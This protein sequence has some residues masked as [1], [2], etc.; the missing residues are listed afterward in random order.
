MTRRGCEGPPSA[1][2]PAIYQ[3]ISTCLADAVGAGGIARD[4]LDRLLPEAGRALAGL[5][6][7]RAAGTQPFLAYA[8]G[9]DNLAALAALA[10][11]WRRRFRRLVV[12]GTGGATLGGQALAATS[13][14]GERL[15][16]LDNGDGDRLDRVL[17]GPDLER[18]G[19][20]VISKSGATAETLAQA[21]LVLGDTKPV[22]VAAVITQP[23]ESPLRRLAA[24]FGLAVLD[25]DPALGGRFS[26]FS[27]VGL[28][29]AMF[30]GVDGKAARDGAQ[31]VLSA[32]LEAPAPE[33]S[34]PAMG[35][36]LAV[37]AMHAWPAASMVLMPYG[38]GL[39][40][41]GFWYRQ[42]WAESLGKD[43]HGSTPILAPGPVDQHSQL[44]LFLDGPGGNLFT[45]LE[46]PETAPRN[47]DPALAEAIG[48]GYLGGHRLGDL[49]AA[50][51]RATATML[52]DAGRPVR[53][54][55]V[56]A[57]D[58]RAIGAL[59]MHFMLETV[60]AAHLLG[61]DPFDQPAVER[62]KE[63]ARRDL[64]AEA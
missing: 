39:I 10:G 6:R 64:E 5:R 38:P 31:A 48:A 11:E 3:D 60:V 28:L 33:D 43:G 20:L 57:A 25:H 55:G 50:Q 14:E 9:R 4:A 44:Q 8:D 41:F 18:T 22:N 56:P 53:R 23:G 32:A 62:G 54:L 47:V 21:L 40:P 26:A 51:A 16:F 58:A 42:L 13:A 52:T 59:M 34:A 24:R 2:A 1:V 63:L 19:F 36:A 30:A 29:P 12:L 49:I 37:A 7:A 45:I 61:V 27:L 17:S 46:A 35:A 15:L